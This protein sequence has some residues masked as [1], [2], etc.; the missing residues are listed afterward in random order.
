M[1]RMN[2]CAPLLCHK[3][4]VIIDISVIMSLS[5]SFDRVDGAVQMCLFVCFGR[6]WVYRVEVKSPSVYP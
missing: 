6:D 2:T 1:A 5:S 3:G 4:N